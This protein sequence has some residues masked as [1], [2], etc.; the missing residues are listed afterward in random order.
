MCRDRGPLRL[1]SRGSQL[2]YAE[3]MPPASGASPPLRLPAVMTERLGERLNLPKVRVPRGVF[4]A[5][6]LK[7]VRSR[8][9]ER[10]SL[11]LDFLPLPGAF[12]EAAIAIRAMIRAKGK[13]GEPAGV[14]L[15]E[16]YRLA[17]LADLLLETPQ[18]EGVGSSFNIAEAVGQSF[19]IS[20]DTPYEEVGYEEL[21]LLNKTDIRWIRE[22]WG[23]P[24]RHQKAHEFHSAFWD[25]AVAVA[26]RK[27]EREEERMAR[28]M[29]EL[30]GSR[31]APTPSSPAKGRAGSGSG[32]AVVLGI[33][34]L[35]I[36][37][38]AVGV[39]LP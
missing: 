25:K 1:L 13:E 26:K 7:T 11:A 31:P 16:L 22:A 32:C 23:E 12:R 9:P 28:Q 3:G 34:F 19:W 18:V 10:L 20:V 8:P 39:T 36:V 38:V 14:L 29:Q 27:R 37:V 4:W 33:F 15:E 35:A 24:S 6:H 30:L 5:E 2:R 17:A 21:S